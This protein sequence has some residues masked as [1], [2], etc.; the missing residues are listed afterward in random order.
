[1]LEL[2]PIF[3]TVCTVTPLEAVETGRGEWKVRSNAGLT[4]VA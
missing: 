3:P 4:R 2:R 1:M